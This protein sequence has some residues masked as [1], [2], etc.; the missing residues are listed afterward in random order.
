MRAIVVLVFLIGIVASISECDSMKED[1]K[2]EIDCSYNGR[3]CHWQSVKK[4]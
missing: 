1:R 3:N 2:V 4:E